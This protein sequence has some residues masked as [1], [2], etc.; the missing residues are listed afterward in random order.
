LMTV[1]FDNLDSSKDA[2][3]DFQDYVGNAMK[4]MISDLAQQIFFAQMFSDLSD[5][6]LAVYKDTSLSNEEKTAQV[7]AAM[8]TFYNGIGQA[9]SDATKF[10]NDMYGSIKTTT[11]IDLSSSTERAGTTAA[12][13][14]AS[15][16][17]ID[18]L[19]GG[20]Y[21]LR[22]SIADI[23]NYNREQMLIFQT[24]T[25]QLDRIADNTEY[26]KLLENIKQYLED[27]NVKGIK[28]KV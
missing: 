2:V 14:T 10:I 7:T 26:C 8:G 23:R 4:K 17:S 5:K 27:M 11:G 16:D 22:S 24:M 1:I 18:E 13:A 15:Q 20:V 19:S 21:A 25:G 3:D 12:L 6:V 9:T 28:V